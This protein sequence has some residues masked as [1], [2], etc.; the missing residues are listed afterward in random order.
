M[1]KMYDVYVT[2]GKAR[3]Y[4]DRQNVMENYLEEYK[5]FIKGLYN[6]KAEL[7][8][9]IVGTE[10]FINNDANVTRKAWENG[11]F[12]TVCGDTKEV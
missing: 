8:F 3:R 12:R 10:V 11:Y 2:V 6:G 4:F 9:E 7:N 1:K 5:E